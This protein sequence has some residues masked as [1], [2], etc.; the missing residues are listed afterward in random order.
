MRS[1]SNRY[2]Y[3]T[4]I[5][6]AVVIGLAIYFS[7]PLLN[8]KIMT[9]ANWVNTPKKEIIAKRSQY[10]TT[11]DLGNNQQAVIISTDP[12][13]YLDHGQW[14]PIDTKIIDQGNNY[15]ST[16]NSFQVFFAKSSNQIYLVRYQSGNDYIEFGLDTHQ[17]WGTLNPVIP[18]VSGNQ[19]TYPSIFP[20][21]NL[22]YTVTAS[23]LLEEFEITD[24]NL[25]GNI[26]QINKIFRMNGTIWQYNPDGG[27]DFF[28]PLN[29]KILWSIPKPV[30]YESKDS[31]NN[32]FG[33]H[34][35]VTPVGDHYQLKKIIDAP[36]KN[37]INNNTNRLPIVI[38]DTVGLNE[39]YQTA[40]GD[41]VVRTNGST[42]QR[43]LTQIKSDIGN[44]SNL[45]YRAFA[46][47]D[48][49]AIPDNASIQSVGLFIDIDNAY[50]AGNTVNIVR[51]DKALS[52]YPD[53]NASNTALFNDIGNA[54]TK[55][56]SAATDFQSTGVTYINL[57][58]K[59]ANS[60]VI[61][62]LNGKL[63]S[64]LPFGI[65]FWG[66][67]ET[68]NNV[69]S[70]WF[71][72]DHATVDMRPELVIFYNGVEGTNDRIIRPLRDAFWDGTNHWVFF[73]SG[74][75]ADYYY[76]PDGSTWTKSGTLNSD[77]NNHYAVWYEKGGNSVW[78]AYHDDTLYGN[79]LAKVGTINGTTITWG[80]ESIAVTGDTSNGYDFP[81]IIRDTNGYCWISGRYYTS[82][83][84]GFAVTKSTT[85]SCTAWNLPTV[86]WSLTSVSNVINGGGYIVPLTNGKLYAVF[87]H[88]TDLLG[89]YYDGNAWGNEESIDATVATGTYNQGMSVV[90][91][92]DVVHLVYIDSDGSLKYM[93]R[94]GS[95]NSAI[96]LDSSTTFYAPSLSRNLVNDNLYVV[97]RNNADQANSGNVYYRSATSPY[98]AGNW[99][100]A[101]T[102]TTTSWASEPSSG[103]TGAW[104]LISNY[105]AN[106]VIEAYWVEGIYGLKSANILNSPDNIAPTTTDSGIDGTTH[107]T[108]VTVILNCNDTG[109]GVCA[110]TYYTTDGTDPTTSSSSGNSFTLTNNGTYTVKYFSVDN[111]G[112]Q[113]SV[114]TA[115]NQVVIN[116]TVSSTTSS[117]SSSSNDTS[118][119]STTP[120]GCQSTKPGNKTPWLYSAIPINST[121][122]TLYFTAADDPVSKYVL[123][124]GTNSG[125]YQYGV[126]DLGI[127]SHQQMTYTVNSLSPNTM[128]YFRIRA[129]NGCAT[130]NWSNE[131]SSST[132]STSGNGQ[133]DIVSSKLTAVPS[134]ANNQKN[135][136]VVNQNYELKIKVTDTDNQPVIGAKVTLHSTPQ[137]KITD[138]NGIAD[139]TDV[140]SGQHQVLIAE[141][142][143]TG[144]Q[145]INLSGKVKE[146]DLS[147]KVKPENPFTALPVIITI[148]LLA[149]IILFL[150]LFITKKRKYLF[151]SH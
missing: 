110:T 108:D 102:L 43:F 149:L 131:I 35:Q 122:I 21:V 68:S 134:S 147:V 118:S 70:E 96:T 123:E 17:P 50:G 132:K 27:I 12:V 41:G 95:W 65:G 98:A 53:S 83:Q 87:K 66:S 120:V 48:T 74:N 97:Y 62:D 31:K 89:K 107:S 117:S 90:A 79:M 59:L 129:G 69:Y 54:G 23:Q 92:G 73:K 88:E 121:A 20:G 46:E 15:S 24:K 13:H 104:P 71:S 39:N 19:I 49:T 84:V 116:K 6:I 94:N 144:T 67:N 2:Q 136:G 82:T 58:Y 11:Y 77:Q 113:E 137:V 36:G 44:V 45:K 76:S 14:L 25:F 133:L 42:Y 112:N 106:G 40:S 126:Q 81:T 124:F 26:D 7:S 38:D 148:S 105:S 4:F 103:A 56:V 3:L 119:S 78:T 30:L 34:F 32:N 8:K 9:Y 127:V 128:Y 57:G 64:N 52:N 101:S 146:F 63:A 16:K 91:I 125:S 100:N 1:L 60:Q 86:L 150:I 114:K 145:S 115:A 109:G 138:K 139:F 22:R 111:L 140:E 142:N 33:V 5:F 29:N 55:Y 80:S 143:Y 10:S 75:N 18:Q 99:S 151:K 51:L 135:I 47:Y 141:N 28:S 85:T 61:T 72:S 37:W 93:N 130:G